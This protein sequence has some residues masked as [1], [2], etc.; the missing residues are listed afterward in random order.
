[1]AGADSKN[2]GMQAAIDVMGYVATVCFALLLAPQVV[3]NQR[4]RSTDGLSLLLVLLWHAAALLYLPFLMQHHAPFPLLLQWTVFQGK[5]GCIKSE[6]SN[7][8]PSIKID[9]LT[10]HHRPYPVVSRHNQH[11]QSRA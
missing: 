9:E 11:T 5:Y 7:P 2:M 1:M 6:R 8:G 4:R 3:L 10:T